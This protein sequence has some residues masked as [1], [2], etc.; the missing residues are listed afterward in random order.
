MNFYDDVLTNKSF[1]SNLYVK[2]FWNVDDSEIAGRVLTNIPDNFSGYL[3]DVP[4][5]TAVFTCEKYSKFNKSRIICLDY[6]KDM[7]EQAEQRFKAFFETA[8]VLKKGGIFTGCFYIK[9]EKLL[10]DFVVSA[11]LAPKGWFTPP[12]Q[13]RK[14][15]TEVLKYYYSEVE[16]STDNAMAIFRC[17]K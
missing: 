12:F 10:T 2:L 7:L 4:V 15:L 8:R 17:I 13:T 3:L 6:S 16:I 1:L 11:V 5:G 9:K 14:E